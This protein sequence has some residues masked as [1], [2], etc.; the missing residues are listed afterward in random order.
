MKRPMKSMA[1]KQFSADSALH[2]KDNRH[3]MVGYRCPAA[4][5][6]LNYRPAARARRAGGLGMDDATTGVFRVAFKLTA[7]GLRA[8]PQFEDDSNVLEFVGAFHAAQQIPTRHQETTS[9]RRRFVAD[10]GIHAATSKDRFRSKE[11]I[12]IASQITS[13][14][15][16]T[17]PSS[18]A[19]RAP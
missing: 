4:C 13:H 3:I 17:R 9:R 16:D 2:C 10:S 5:S 18:R 15:F 8:S 1:H 19:S 6:L 14:G 11:V 7:E 12:R